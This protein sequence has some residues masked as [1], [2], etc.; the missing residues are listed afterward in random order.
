[1]KNTARC[2]ARPVASTVSEGTERIQHSD[3]L[4]DK[5]LRGHGKARATD[6]DKCRL[7]SRDYLDTSPTS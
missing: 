6:I 7:A 5:A 1:M 2:I 4:A 3:M